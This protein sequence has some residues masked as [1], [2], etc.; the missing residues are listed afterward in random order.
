MKRNLIIKFDDSN[1]NMLESLT[2]LSAICK[3]D[4]YVIHVGT[5]PYLCTKKGIEDA[6]IHFVRRLD[7]ECACTKL[8]TPLAVTWEAFGDKDKIKAIEYIVEIYDISE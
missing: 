4:G 2:D 5:T 3:D 1:E 8:H 6:V 7:E